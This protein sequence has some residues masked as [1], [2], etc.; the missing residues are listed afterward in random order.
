MSSQHQSPWADLPVPEHAATSGDQGIGGGLD[1]GAGGN[2]LT[3]VPWA[4]AFVPTPSGMDESGPF[5]NP[6]RYS[7]VDGSTQK[8]TDQGG[9]VGNITGSR[10]TIDKR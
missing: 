8:G 2:G 5:G 1:S 6:S 10:N 9:P 7:S 4:G 3:S